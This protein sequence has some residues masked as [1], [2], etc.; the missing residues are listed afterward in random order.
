MPLNALT[1]MEDIG[2]VI[3]CF[4]TF[5][6]MGLY[7]EG[8]RLNPRADFVPHERTVHEAQGGMGLGVGREMGI[9]VYG[10]PPPHAQDAAALGLPHFGTPERRRARE[11]QG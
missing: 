1:Q 8:P 11:G 7:D 2:S 9:K 4:P 3:Q 5:G 10:V 6:Q